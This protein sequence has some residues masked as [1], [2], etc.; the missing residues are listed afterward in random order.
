MSTVVRKDW[1]PRNEYT[2]PIQDIPMWRNSG[3]IKAVTDDPHFTEESG[4]K[5]KDKGEL[6]SF[7]KRM[8][9]DRY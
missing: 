5:M 3:I 2:T 7:C 9:R 4:S 1:I 6:V 8:Q